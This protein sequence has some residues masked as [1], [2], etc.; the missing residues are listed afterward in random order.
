[1]TVFAQNIGRSPVVELGAT[2]W[3]SWKVEHSF[4][5]S[6]LPSGTEIEE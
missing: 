1:V 4:G 5:L 6:D 2:V 3:V